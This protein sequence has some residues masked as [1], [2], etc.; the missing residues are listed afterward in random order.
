MA[1]E[2]VHN[3]PVA[4]DSLLFDGTTYDVGWDGSRVTSGPDTPLLPSLDHVIYLMNAVKFHCGQIFHLFDEKSFTEAIYD[5]YAEPAIRIAR[6][7]LIYIHLLLVVAFGKAVS[8]QKGLSRR[9][10]GCDYFAKALQLLPGVHELCKE[11]FISAEILCCIAL[12][13]QCLDYRYGAHNFVRSPALN[14][15]SFC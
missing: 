8:E 11:P 2:Y 12:Y 5:F 3:S 14:I 6:A 10:P 15:F 9:P 7:D 4:P 1:H 13:F